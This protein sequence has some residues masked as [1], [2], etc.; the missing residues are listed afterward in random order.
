MDLSCRCIFY[1]VCL[2]KGD[3]CYHYYCLF[4]FYTSL[5]LFSVV[6]YSAIY[7]FASFFLFCRCCQSAAAFFPP[8]WFLVRCAF[9]F[10]HKEIVFV[11]M[12]RCTQTN[13]KTF[14]FFF[15]IDLLHDKRRFFFFCCV[16][17]Y[18]YNGCLKMMSFFFSSSTLALF[19]EMSP[20]RM[21][22]M[23]AVAEGKPSIENDGR[24]QTAN[25]HAGPTQQEG[26]Q[27]TSFLA[28]SSVFFFFFTSMV[29]CL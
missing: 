16:S 24:V 5:F 18:M 1:S 27:H 4:F 3:S 17:Y 8:L 19:A 14:L 23:G 13:A 15:L 26:R 10:I 28:L 20:G 29:S 6:H 9:Y 7:I 2:V 21:A 12:D 11:M 22:A 25:A